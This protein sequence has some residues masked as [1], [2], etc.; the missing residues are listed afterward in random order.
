M[1]LGV[2]TSEGPHQ[3][4]EH[5]AVHGFSTSLWKNGLKAGGDLPVVEPMVNSFCGDLPVKDL[6]VQP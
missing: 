2:M 5:A 1:I 4:P 3:V 6:R